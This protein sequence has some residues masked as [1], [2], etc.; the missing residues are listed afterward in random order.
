MLT[1]RKG[2]DYMR[3]K[4]YEHDAIIGTLRD[5]LFGRTKSITQQFPAHFK[6]DEERTHVLSPAM[7][8]LAA[9]AVSIVIILL[10]IVIN[11]Y[12]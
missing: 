7:V 5:T 2:W 10:L 8:A 3:E 11:A 4:P 1:T 9:T 6:P 12:F